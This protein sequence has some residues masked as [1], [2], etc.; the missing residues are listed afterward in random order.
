MEIV[1]RSVVVRDWGWGDG[2]NRSTKS[3]KNRGFLEQRILCM[4]LTGGYV[5]LYICPNP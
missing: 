2:T 4:I 3:S 1:K 5:S